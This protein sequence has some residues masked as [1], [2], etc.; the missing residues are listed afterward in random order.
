VLPPRHDLCGVNPAVDIGATDWGNQG[1]DRGIA[2]EISIMRTTMILAWCL[3][4]ASA[5]VAQA[6]NN[7]DDKLKVGDYAPDLEAE[8]WINV[9]SKLDVPSLAEMRGL[10]V[11]VFFWVSSHS[12]GEAV[13]P[14][15]T[16][17]ENSEIGKTSGVYSIGLTDATRKVTE[18]IQQQAMAFFPIGTK[19]KSAEEYG[20]DG[21]FGFV[22]IDA[23][24]KLAFRGGGTDLSALSNAVQD[25][26]KKNPP[27]KT[28]PREAKIVRKL[29]TEARSQIKAGEY[30]LAFETARD[31][32]GRAVTGD[33]LRSEVMDVIDLLE[34]LG[35]ERIDRAKPLIEQKKFAEAADQLRAVTR[36]FAPPLD[37]G[38]DARDLYDAY[39]DEIDGFRD[40][41]QAH[42]GEDEAATL[43][44]DARIDL[45]AR[46]FG[47][48]HQK[49]SQIMTDYSGTKAAKYA[50]EMIERMKA[51]EAVWSYVLDHGAET[52]CETWL[53][54][55]RTHIRHGRFAEARRLLR[56]IR[57]DYPGTSYDLEA[58]D[59][60]IEMPA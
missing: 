11:V 2:Q 3:S 58:R 53:A 44:L 16:Q 36:E 50:K 37:A 14:N 32:F 30:R 18:R 24:G 33:I 49:L 29:L 20:V 23:E 55:A 27:T 60:L 17:F 12:G 35:Y 38:I 28:H 45:Q 57:E 40:A 21:G 15:V 46:R 56:R 48:S 9:E 22:V 41:V 51:N 39:K 4:L 8:D 1:R 43:F 59:L 10:V 54:Q 13:L 25:T 26:L 47:E 19:S 52:Q 31:A 6:Q 5:G 34:A 42:F 7:D